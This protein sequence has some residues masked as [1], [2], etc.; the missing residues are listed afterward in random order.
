M[1]ASPVPVTTIASD[2]RS[3]RLY[4]NERLSHTPVRTLAPSTTGRMKIPSRNSR[5]T[6]SAKT[7]RKR[8]MQRKI[9]IEAMT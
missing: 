2:V 5:P 6:I 1:A 8:A 7:S 4:Q 9:T 3:S